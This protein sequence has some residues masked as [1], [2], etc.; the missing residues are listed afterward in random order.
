MN[1]SEEE[2]KTK[3]YKDY[4]GKE[5]KWDLPTLIYRHFVSG[6][7]KFLGNNFYHD[8]KSKEVQK[9]IKQI[10]KQ[11]KQSPLEV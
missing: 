5:K 1:L 9:Q 10:L 2:L 11:I 7:G 8:V 3:R 4:T 6:K